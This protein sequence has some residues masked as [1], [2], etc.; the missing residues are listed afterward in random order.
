MSGLALVGLT[1]TKV[2]S[3]RPIGRSVTRQP[4][5]SAITT[6]AA[7]ALVEDLIEARR[8]MPT[9]YRTLHAALL[10]LADQDE[11]KG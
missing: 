2:L 4:T 5:E 1:L 7:L 9:E 10:L 3:P 11:V 6:A 8:I